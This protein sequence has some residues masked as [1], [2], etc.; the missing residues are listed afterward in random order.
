M[1]QRALTRVKLRI[2]IGVG[3]SV[4]C[5]WLAVS[6]APLGLL[7]DG[8][9]QVNYWWLVPAGLANLLVNWARGCRWRALLANRGPQEE[10]FWAQAI[11]IA[12]TNLLP[13]RAGD[14]ARM[15]I[16]S[17]RAGLPLAQVAASLVLE[18]LTDLAVVLAL[19]T[20]LLLLMDVPPA[21]TV[22]GLALGALLVLAST[23]VI[24]LLLF[25][26]RLTGLV[27]RV[28]GRLPD[29]SA[30]WGLETWRHLLTT[31]EPLHDLRMVLQVLG[32]STLLWVTGICS[33]W[34][35]IEAVA[36]GAHPIEPAFAL[37]ALALGV[38]LPSSP[39]FI[40][41]YQLIGQQALVTP[42]PDRYTAASAL[43]IAVL[44]HATYYLV[45]TALGLLG[46]ARLGLSLQAAAPSATPPPPQNEMH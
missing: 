15:L 5:L 3:V 38:A 33:F 11:G 27:E 17:R 30:R 7:A 24:V 29:R 9:R 2:W 8:L 23:A 18:W 32:W 46:L 19:L 10:Y 41:V 1:I 28:A 13:L 12:V 16:L 6:Q 40:G 14:A 31:L 34:A 39:G 22:T 26:H 4:A 42:F 45:T 43:L 44:S 36:P 20:G 35:T 21:V 37:T 25:G